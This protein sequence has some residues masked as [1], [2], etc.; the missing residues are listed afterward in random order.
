MTEMIKGWCKRQKVE[1]DDF[2]MV[3]V[4]LSGILGQN[5]AV[6]FGQKADK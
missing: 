2:I 5:W 6:N 1:G 4:L 3:E